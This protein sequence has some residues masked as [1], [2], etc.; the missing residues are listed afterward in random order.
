MRSA[1]MIF[2]CV[3][4]TAGVVA[5][6]GCTEKK[7]AQQPKK[8]ETRVTPSATKASP[9]INKVQRQT[10]VQETAVSEKTPKREDKPTSDAKAI[11]GSLVLAKPNEV[12]L[13]VARDFPGNKLASIRGSV[14]VEGST[15]VPA[16]L[17]PA[18]NY[19]YF[20]AK[21]LQDVKPPVNVILKLS[22]DGYTE[23]EI[24]TTIAAIVKGQENE[25]IVPSASNPREYTALV[26]DELERFKQSVAMGN[27]E[28]A[29]EVLGNLRE[30]V[31][32]LALTSKENVEMALQAPLTSI[33]TAITS[34][35]EA[36]KKGDVEEARNIAAQ[37]EAVIE[38]R[39]APYFVNE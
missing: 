31:N 20:S 29:G 22:A 23:A 4:A 11:L 12:R 9:K 25:K 35:T 33:D 1:F 32:G 17:Y 27:L 18:L 19:K 7:E 38:D 37:V 24:R 3:V 16:H 34:M 26:K 6:T 10:R 8:Q 28:L 5:L 13:F 39:V 2:A 30:S 36:Q 21:L 14:L 15:S